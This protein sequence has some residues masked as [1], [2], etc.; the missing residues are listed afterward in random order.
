[1][2]FPDGLLPLTFSGHLWFLQYLF[3]ISLLTLPLL[4][5]LHSKQSLNF[6]HK[7]AEWCAQR[8]GIFLFLIPVILV[9]VG[10]RSVFWGEHTW[11]DFFEFMVFFLIG[12]ILPANT[13]FTECIQKYAWICLTLGLASFWGEFI[14]IRRLGYNYPGREQFC[15]TFILFE[16]MMSIGRWSWIVFVLSLGAKYLNFHNKALSYGSEAVLPFYILH[17][18]II[19][20]VGWLVI[21]LNMGILPKYVLIAVISLA[22]IMVL[23]E[24]LIRRFNMVRFCFG[25]RPM[26]KLSAMHI[27]VHNN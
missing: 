8:G 11:A 4:R 17:Q 23:Y 9:R 1:M 25:M 13:R 3:L 6:T 12:Y 21:P 19:L 26:K 20:C 2:K 27:S 15:L 5:Y 18:T 22:L 24:L 16:I 10:L 14:F 7:L